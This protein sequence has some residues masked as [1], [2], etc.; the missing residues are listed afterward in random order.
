[1]ER[2]AAKNAAAGI[3]PKLPPVLTPVRD[4][5]FTSLLALLTGVVYDA[6]CVVR[7]RRKQNFKLNLR[8]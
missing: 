3:A 5:H 6:P 1:M 4:V 2:E 7:N 8:Y